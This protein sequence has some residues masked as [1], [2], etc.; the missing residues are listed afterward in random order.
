MKNLTDQEIIEL[1]IACKNIVQWNTQREEIKQVRSN[2][3]IIAN[4]DTNALI[5]KTGIPTVST[6]SIQ[7]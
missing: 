5:N 1:M 2:E 4:I 3:W 7:N 6:K